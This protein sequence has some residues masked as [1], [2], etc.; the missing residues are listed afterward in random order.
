MSLDIHNTEASKKP[1]RTIKKWINETLR[2]ELIDGRVITGILVCTDNVPNLI[3]NCGIEFWRNKEE[4]YLQ[5]KCDNFYKRNI[6]M[7]FYYK[8][9]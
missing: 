9:I 3:I 5:G 8:F 1:K 7:V 2:I 6:G 4:L